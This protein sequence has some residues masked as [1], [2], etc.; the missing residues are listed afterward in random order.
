M[1]KMMAT[2]TAT[3]LGTLALAGIATHSPAQAAFKPRQATVVTTG[4]LLLH[5]RMWNT[6]I[7]DGKNG[8]WD[9]FPQLS[10]VGKIIKGADLALCH[11]ETPLAPL[12]GPYSGYPVFKSPPQIVS[13]IKR[14]GFDMCDQTSNH[15]FD[16][17]EAGV[18]RTIKAFDAAGIA[19]T[20][21]YA[22]PAD[23][24]KPLVMTVSTS[25]GTIKVGICAFTYGFNGFPYPN[26]HTWLANQTSFLK[27][28][29]GVKDVRAAGAEIVIVK[30]HWGTE[31]ASYPNDNQQVLARKIAKT[32]LV[33]LIDGDHTHSVEPMQKIGRMWVAYSHGNLIAAQ[34]DPESIQYEGLISRWTFTEQANH[35]FQVTRAEYAP[36]LISRHVPV[37][38]IDVQRALGTGHWAGVTKARLDKA[39]ARTSKTILSMNA[40]AQLIAQ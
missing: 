32:G 5:E 12:G 19:H 17:G 24:K 38:V 26:G 40:P 8:Q 25:T 23:S 3:A 27:V 15:S 29:Q 21:T 34:P 6:A 22:S 13:A 1:H 33:D 37:R 4:D 18:K 20:G 10:G 35:R 39:M 2:V 9:F 30:L 7:A 16:A 14:L 11:Q 31:Y 36:T 28:M